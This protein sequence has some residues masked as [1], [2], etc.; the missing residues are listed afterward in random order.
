MDPSDALFCTGPLLTK[1]TTTFNPISWDRFFCISIS[2]CSLF[3]GAHLQ[4][5]MICVYVSYASALSRFRYNRHC[6]TGN[7]FDKNYHQISDISRIKSQN[8]YVLLSSCK[9]LRPIHWRQVLSRKWRCSWSSTDRR[10][11]IY[12]WLINKFIA[13]RCDLC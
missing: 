3:S 2:V 4:T 11:S 10:C 6:T 7:Q 13:L 9:C 8:L 5:S 1:T 12:I